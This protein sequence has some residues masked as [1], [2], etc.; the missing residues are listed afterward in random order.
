M[1]ASVLL[2]IAAVLTLLHG[3]LHTIGGAF[4]QPPPGAQETA[5]LAMKA[6]QFPAMGVMRTY[7]DFFMGYGL[8]ITV[9][10]LV[11]A[12]VFWQ[13]AS[14]VKT[15]AGRARPMVMAFS[16]SYMAYAVVSLRYFFV[17]PVVLELVI[18]LCLLGAWVLAARTERM[19]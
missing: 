14:L 17:A 2:R 10:F 15:D 18:A 8:V 19:A 9:G 12:V 1:K 11:Q 13:L 4:G 7:W 3:V 6:N 16:V 5:V